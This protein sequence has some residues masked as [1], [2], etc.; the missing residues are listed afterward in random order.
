MHKNPVSGKWKLVD[1]H[2]NYEHSSAGYYELG[3]GAFDLIHYEDADKSTQSLPL[4]RNSKM[5]NF[6]A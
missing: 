1:D 2:V 5:K 3:R 6:N 4:K